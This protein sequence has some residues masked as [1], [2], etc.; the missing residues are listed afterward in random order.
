ML[1]R[2]VQGYQVVKDWAYQTDIAT[3]RIIRTEYIDLIKGM[4]VIKVGFC[5]E[6]SGITIATKSVQRGCC[7][8]D[9]GYYLYESR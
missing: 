4:L 8:H 2:K 6:P 5:F 9:A 7:A 1:Y 3:D